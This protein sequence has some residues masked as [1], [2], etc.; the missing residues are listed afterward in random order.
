MIEPCYSKISH[1]RY[2]KL[3]SVN[4]LLDCRE[5]GYFAQYNKAN[6]K[7]LQNIEKLMFYVDINIGFMSK[8]FVKLCRLFK[9]MKEHADKSIDS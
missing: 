8:T 9:N 3:N 1:S 7:M 6:M 2:F 5:N 4:L